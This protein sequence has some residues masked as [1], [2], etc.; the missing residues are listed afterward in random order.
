MAATRAGYAK[1]WNA[2]TGAE[3]ASPGIT[4]TAKAPLLG[5][6]LKTTRFSL[7]LTSV[8]NC[9]ANGVV[10]EAIDMETQRRFAV[11][12]M[13]INPKVGKHSAPDAL[14]PSMHHRMEATLHAR[15]S[16]HPRVLSL[17]DAAYNMYGAYLVLDYCPDGDLFSL[18]CD[19]GLR[20]GEAEAKRLFLEA[21]Q[22]VAHCHRMG[23]YH[24]DIKP[25]NLL[26][27]RDQQGRL[28][29]YLAD[30]GLA[31]E[32]AWSNEHGYGSAFYMSPECLQRSSSTTSCNANGAYPSDDEGDFDPFCYDSEEDSDHGDQ[33]YSNGQPFSTAASDVWS[34]GVLLCN[35]ASRR[36]PWR[37]ADKNEVAYA[38]YL[39]D[40]QNALARILPI[41]EEVHAI[42]RR[43]LDPNPRTR[44]T[45]DELYESVRACRNFWSDEV[46]RDVAEVIA[47][48][49]AKHGKVSSP[50][51]EPESV[52]PSAD[53]GCEASV[54]EREPHSPIPSLENSICESTADD[55]DT[56]D[57]HNGDN[58][59]HDQFVICSDNHNV[60]A[61]SPAVVDHLV[62]TSKT[63]DKVITGIK[64][65]KSMTTQVQSHATG[66]FVISE[67]TRQSSVVESAQAPQPQPNKHH[68]TS[69]IEQLLPSSWGS[70]LARVLRADLRAVIGLAP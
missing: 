3:P 44:C 12:H 36:N 51:A 9:G 6:T 38:Y 29:V 66:E 11:K 64:T 62:L 67:K 57:D 49:D 18:I 55:S 34:L 21:C 31:T 27:Q 42:L 65:P 69:S 22:A 48:Y 8:L 15:C 54:E 30:F 46:R 17:H 25:E 2:N 26:L 24:R 32:H 50:A 70:T 33:A 4:P 68:R 61:S 39:R 52:E 10:Y 47:A 60:Y 63:G 20:G 28:H 23:V 56:D 19:T 40:T 14:T 59:D 58:D 41:T 37:C 45:L 5:Q 13:P 35:M 1:Q 43:A 7:R 16:G 53:A